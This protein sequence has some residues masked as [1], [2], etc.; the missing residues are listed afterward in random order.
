MKTQAHDI[1]TLAIG[2]FVEFTYNGKL[3][4]GQLDHVDT[5]PQGDYRSSGYVRLKLSDGSYKNFNIEKIQ[6]NISF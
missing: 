3:R 1:H 5:N 2:T 6:S 4:K